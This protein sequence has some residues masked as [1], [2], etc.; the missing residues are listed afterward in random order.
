MSGGLDQHLTED[1]LRW[2]EPQLRDEDTAAGQDLLGLLN[3]MFEKEFIQVGPHGRQPSC[4][5]NGLAD[6]IRQRSRS[7]DRIK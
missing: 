2:L 7:R 4:G 3:V 5:R 6:G 1:Y